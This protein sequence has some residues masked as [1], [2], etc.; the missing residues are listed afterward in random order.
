MPQDPGW[1]VL[2]DSAYTGE[3]GWVY[4]QGEIF[5]NT[6]TNQENVLLIVAFYDE[7]DRQV[8]EETTA[9]VVE[10]IPQGSKVPFILETELRLPYER[11]EVTAEGIPTDRQP[12]MDLEI[13]DHTSTID[14]VYRITGEIYNPGAPL[15]TYVEVIATLYDDAGRVVNLGYDF[16]IADELGAGE[17][18]PFEVLIEAPYEGVARYALVVLGF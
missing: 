10:V 15:S 9:P 13:Q 5:N 18:A 12:R 6:G 8:G 14:E 17:A 3:G 7:Q 2:N 11:Y 1:H 4:V 16:L